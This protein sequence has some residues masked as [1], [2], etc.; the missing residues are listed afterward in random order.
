MKRAARV[1]SPLAA[2]VAAC[3]L[4]G[5]SERPGTPP[6]L[7]N[8]WAR[9]VPHSDVTPT[10]E[11]AARTATSWLGG[12]RTTATGETVTVYV[13]ASLPAEL[14]TPQ[15][16][17]DFLAGLVHGR[18]LSNLTAYIGT[19]T[20]IGEMCG[21]HALGCYGGNRMAAIGQRAFGISAEEVVRH[22]YGHHVA[23]NRVNPPWTAI[24]WGPKRW[25]SQ[26]S[27]CRRAAGGGIFP[28]DEGD[29]YQLNPGEAWAETYRI[30]VEKKVGAIGSGWGLVD[31]SFLPDDAAL[32]AAERDVIQPWTATTRS[33]FRTRF[34]AKGKRVWSIPIT[35]A[36]D[37][38]VAITLGLPRGGVHDAVLVDRDRKAKLATALWAGPST[39]RITTTVCG[40]R[41]LVLTIRH[42]GAFGQVVAT[43][44]KP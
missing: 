27:I 19:L 15:S 31:L 9:A 4:A 18:E 36:L 35:T 17:A 23:G 39:K 10:R 11:R 37:G 32:D 1:L 40:S 25:A 24:D 33:M 30:M 8:G 3:A 12:A 20:E 16:W 44:D 38:D 34:T 22:E 21:P 26:A 29:N 28:G 14:G 42:R 7:E 13:S 2:A 41:S 5:P 43:V 6:V